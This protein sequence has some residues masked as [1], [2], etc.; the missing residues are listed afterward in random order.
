MTKFWHNLE[1]MLMSR[2]VVVGCSIL[3]SAL[4]ACSK[5][6]NVD[7]S[8]TNV[9]DSD[10]DTPCLLTP[11]STCAPGMNCVAMD[12]QGL[13]Q[14]LQAGTV[15]AYAACSGPSDCEV[16]YGCANGVCKQYCRDASDCTGSGRYCVQVVADVGNG[17]Q[18]DVPGFKVCSQNCDPFTASPCGDGTTCVAETDTS[19]WWFDCVAAGEGKGAGA[20][21]S[22]NP[23]TCAR[24]YACSNTIPFPNG[25]TPEPDIGIYANVPQNYC[26]KWCKW[27]A[28]AAGSCPSG[29]TCYLFQQFYTGDANQICNPD[30]YGVCY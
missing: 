14:C 26:A 2:L 18:A 22:D 11:E 27:Q 1:D 3:L 8:N 12:N 20:C 5:T 24:G 23:L 15:S 17:T 25:P 6:N 10:A 28:G 19:L 13:T 9:I 7:A 21:S 29:Q 16:G 4:S 30:C